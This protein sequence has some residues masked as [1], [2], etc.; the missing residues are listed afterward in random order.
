MELPDENIMQIQIKKDCEIFFDGASQ[1]LSAA[2][3]DNMDKSSRIGIV[4]V[5][6]DNGIIM[7]SLTLTKGHSNNETE[8]KALITCLE[9][10]LKIPIDDLTVHGDLEL[11]VRQMNG[12][13]HFKKP[14]LTPYFQRAKDLVKLFRCLQIQHVRRDH[15]RQADALAS[16]THL[17]HTQGMTTLLSTLEKEGLSP[18]CRQPWKKMSS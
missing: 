7:H 4:F 2:P 5:I 8:Y 6:P 3:G 9:L 18:H 14:S 12:L 11:V 13:Y 1:G 15:N 16:L 10:A 17:S